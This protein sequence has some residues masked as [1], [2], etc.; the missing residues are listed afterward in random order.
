MHFKDKYKEEMKPDFLSEDFKKK[1]SIRMDLEADNDEQNADIISSD[2]SEDDKEINETSVRT[3]KYNIKKGSNNMFIKLIAAIASALIIFSISLFKFNDNDEIINDP[4]NIITNEPAKTVIGTENTSEK[5]SH[6]SGASLKVTEHSV[7]T[8]ENTA[9]TSAPQANVSQQAETKA[10]ENKASAQSIFASQ[11]DL[12]K[13]VGLRTA[14]NSP[15][16]IGYKAAGYDKLYGEYYDV[17]FTDKGYICTFSDPKALAGNQDACYRVYNKGIYTA[18]E[19]TKKTLSS[20]EL[21]NYSRLMDY[22]N[23]TV[24]EDNYYIYDIY[25][26]D[27][28]EDY[29]VQGNSSHHKIDTNGK[30][31]YYIEIVLKDYYEKYKKLNHRKDDFVVSFEISNLHLVCTD[32]CAREDD[33]TTSESSTDSEISSE[34]PL[35][36]RSHELSDAFYNELNQSYSDCAV[37]IGNITYFDDIPM[38]GVSKPITSWVKDTVI[39][40]PYYSSYSTRYFIDSFTESNVTINDEKFLLDISLFFK[41]G[42]TKDDVNAHLNELK[43]LFEKYHIHY[44]TTDVLNNESDFERYKNSEG[45]VFDTLIDSSSIDRYHA[46]YNDFKPWGA[47]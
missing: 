28:N 17:T 30:S 36:R 37:S 44:I 39:G 42:T 45:Y 7:I 27:I 29:T 22:I 32:N 34:Y 33:Q 41:P 4:D 10:S 11:D 6:T 18:E 5:I 35:F 24:G 3:I 13:Y 46:T 2:G 23:K 15:L 20:D 16:L 31:N 25:Q 8:S 40:D 14:E 26:Y 12:I 9:V 43:P 1:L 19:A 21:A 47:K 38:S